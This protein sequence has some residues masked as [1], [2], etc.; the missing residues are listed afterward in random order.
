MNFLEI[1]AKAPDIIIL[2][3]INNYISLSDFK[4]KKIIIYFYPKDDTS[5][6]TAEACNLRDNYEDLIAKG[7]VVIG[8]SAD[9]EKSHIKFS[10]KY[11]LPFYLIA[12][13]NK[14]IIKAYGVW[15]K[16]KFM[17]KEYEGILRTTFISDENGIIQHVIKKIDTKNLT[18]QIINELK[19]N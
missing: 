14:D 1:G 4:G 12:D 13:V 19:N 18:Q 9:N 8:V 15:G 6:C 16:K 3:Q 7:F 11:Q 5:G 2:N 10:E 17:G